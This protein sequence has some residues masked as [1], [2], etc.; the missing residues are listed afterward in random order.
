[1]HESGVG[2]RLVVN[3]HQLADGSVGVF[4]SGRERLMAEKFLNGAK[5]SPV[6]KQM[7]G[8]GVTQ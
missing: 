3:I 8:E 5:I 7:R 2:V 1:M 6:G 4:L